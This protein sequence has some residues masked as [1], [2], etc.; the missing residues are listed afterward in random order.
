MSSFSTEFTASSVHRHRLVLLDVDVV[1]VVA[2][3]VADHEQVGV[4]LHDRLAQVVQLV[5]L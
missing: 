5:V 2:D 3:A 4:Q 1:Q